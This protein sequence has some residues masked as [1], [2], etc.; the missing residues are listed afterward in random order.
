MANKIRFDHQ[1][2]LQMLSKGTPSGAVAKHFGVSRQAIYDI[3]RDHG[4]KT[5]QVPAPVKPAKKVA[6]INPS[7][8]QIED[9]LIT[10]IAQAKEARKLK[11]ELEA[12]K[13]ELIIVRE[14]NR[15][16]QNKQQEKDRREREWALAQQQ[17]EIGGRNA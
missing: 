14:E 3:K 6:I 12:T 16:L 5:D 1:E 10:T 9:F 13:N 8:D 7:F 17:G 2:A 15:K 4:E 11:N